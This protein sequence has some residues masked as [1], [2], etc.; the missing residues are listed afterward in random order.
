M[1]ELIS[2]VGA[3][4]AVVVTY[5]NPVIAL[6]LGVIFL[7]ESPGA[8]SIAGLVLILAGSW[9]STGGKLSPRRYPATE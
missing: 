8:G 1:A 7:S 6:L 5:V 4:R 3:G 2:T 9:L